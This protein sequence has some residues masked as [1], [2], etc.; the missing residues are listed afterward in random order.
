MND[1]FNNESLLKQTYPV[2][3]TNKENQ[4]QIYVCKMN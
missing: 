2:K 4:R 3:D 1:D